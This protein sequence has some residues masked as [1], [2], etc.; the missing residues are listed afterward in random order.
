MA[1]R[2]REGRKKSADR[3]SANAPCALGVGGPVLGKA[4]FDAIDNC[5]P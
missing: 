1:P 5:I 3:F 4:E 2:K